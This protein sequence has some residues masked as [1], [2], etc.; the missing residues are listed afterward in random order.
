MLTLAKVVLASAGLFVTIDKVTC[1]GTA[2]GQG[3]ASGLR[4]R[5][6]S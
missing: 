3:K 1:E 5:S 2:Q 6:I 4:E